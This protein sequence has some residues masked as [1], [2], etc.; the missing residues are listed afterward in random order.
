MKQYDCNQDCYDVGETALPSLSRL[1]LVV[2]LVLFSFFAWAFFSEISQHVRGQGRV[3]PSGKIRNIQHLEGGIIREI[4]VQ[5][6]DFVKSGQDL[7][8][9]DNMD[10]STSLNEAL[11]KKN[12][13]EIHL[14]RLSAEKN[15]YIDPVFPE[16]LATTYSDIVK[17]E[18]QLF[19]ARK[20]AFERAVNVLE[21]QKEQKRLKLANLVENGRNLEAELAVALQQ[22]RLNEKLVEAGSVSQSKYLDAQSRVGDFR[23]RIAQIEKEIPVLVSEEKEIKN[24]LG[25]ARKRNE[26]DII[27]EI[28]E[29]SFEKRQIEERLNSFDDKVSRSRIVSPVSGIVNT[30]YVDTIGGVVGPGEVIADILP[31]SEQLVVEG[32]ISTD[33]R[34]KIYPGLPVKI[35]L[36]AYDFRQNNAIDGHLSGISADS[37][38]DQQGHSF[39]KIKVAIKTD[40]LPEDTEVFP[41]MIVDLNIMA[42]RVTVLEALLKP[43]LNIKNNALRKM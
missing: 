1:L 37:F 14:V 34:A 27:E 7:F 41:G 40:V 26:S 19:E 22:L 35:R 21:D 15:G 24:K 39:Y 30:R 2:V 6:G 36:S 23:T 13:L 4:L 5:E 31:V 11:I 32:Q 42:E 10:A 9:I 25:Q 17:A 38:M 20:R 8:V 33:D 29:A 18:T 43:F 28:N 16:H 12:E 3:I